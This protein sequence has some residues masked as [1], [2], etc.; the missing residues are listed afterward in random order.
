MP[1]ILAYSFAAKHEAS[2]TL[3]TD[4]RIISTVQ[5]SRICAGF[6]GA[7]HD[8]ISAS[9]HAAY[10]IRLTADASFLTCAAFALGIDEISVHACSAL[11]V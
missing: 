10:A 4:V 3:T 6:A 1:S 8:S 9:T 7:K 2:S 5:T 11:A